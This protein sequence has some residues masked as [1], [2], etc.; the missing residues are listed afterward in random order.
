MPVG[1]MIFLFVVFVVF[2]ALD[3]FMVVTLSLP[4]DERSQT[5]VWKAGNFTLLA[6]VGGGILDI[7]ENLVRNQPMTVNPFIQ[8]EVAAILYFCAL[9][10][11]KRKLGG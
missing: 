3:L 1:A 2:A 9:L 7:I 6:M 11:Y 4:G 5:I 10:F 8:L